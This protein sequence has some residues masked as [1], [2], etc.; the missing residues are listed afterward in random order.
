MSPAHG[1]YQ[2]TAAKEYYTT[3]QPYN[4]TESTYAISTYYAD[5]PKV[6]TT[7][8]T[9]PAYTVVPK[10]YTT[11]NAA[12]AYYTEALAYFNTKAVKHYTE[13]HKNYY[14]PKYTTTT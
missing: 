1:G 3:P 11:M 5:A 6:Y 12:Q 7:K 13:P 10:Y 2:A 14:A 8:Y 9:L 4:T